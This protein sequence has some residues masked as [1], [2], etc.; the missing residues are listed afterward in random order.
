MYEDL[1]ARDPVMA[2]R[3]KPTDRQRISRALEVLAA[4]GRSL[5]DWQAEPPLGPPA[6]L[7]FATTCFLPPRDDLY[8]A[9]DA[10]LRRMVALGAVAEV[11]E[12]CEIHARHVREGRGDGEESPIMKALGVPHFQAYNDGELDLETAI[13]KAQQSTRQYAKR[14]ITW[15][16]NNFI[17]QLMINKKYSKNSNEKIFAFIRQKLLTLDK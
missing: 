4:T 14:Q 13:E 17:S 5:A 9:C 6:G 15:F 11:A 2:T 8:A 3:L 7:R 1:T 16:T 12:A 10:R